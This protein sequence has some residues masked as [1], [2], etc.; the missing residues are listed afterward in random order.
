MIAY[1]S[2]AFV[3]IESKIHHSLTR[4][5]RPLQVGMFWRFLI[6]MFASSCL[7]MVLYV[8]GS[9]Y[10]QTN[11][12]RERMSSPQLEQKMEV[13][14]L[15]ALP[16]LRAAEPFNAICANVLRTL[17]QDIFTMDVLPR[18]G[19][20]SIQEVERDR[21][22]DLT[23]VRSNRAVC[24]Y[25]D[26]A[27]ATDAEGKTSFSHADIVDA[28]NWTRLDEERGGW[29]KVSSIAPLASPSEKL[30]IGVHIY[31]AREALLRLNEFPWSA[32]VPFIALLNLCCA[33]SLVPL[34]VRRIRRAQRVAN[35][36]TNG[37]VSARIHDDRQDEFGDLIH[38]F[39]HLADSFEDVIKVKQDLAA[40]D[41][42]N[43]LARDLHDT[44]KQ[45]AFALNL[46]LT[47]LTLCSSNMEQSKRIAITA[48]SLVHHLQSDLSAVIK[49]L[50]ASTIAE[51][52][53]RKV[54]GQEIHGL[55]SGAGISWTID[56]SDKVD[57][58]LQATPELTQQVFLIAIEAV[59]NALRHSSTKTIE[60]TMTEMKGRYFLSV[61]D[62]GS[63]FDVQRSSD[64]GMGLAN[65]RLRARS[66]PGSIFSIVS[67]AQA[68]TTILVEFNL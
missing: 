34:L 42:R 61:L 43:K 29:H 2:A 26:R 53:I 24:S 64:V 48:L 52:G 3:N 30:I 22:F 47:A 50:S 58:A 19:R 21:R 18:D 55:L 23:Y 14:F 44:A 31:D 41:E 59:A 15:N 5:M 32:V 8:I 36:W 68:G 62:N 33:F 45:R 56:I 10:Y 37:E 20:N 6:A 66:L 49:R 60:L 57:A 40:A 67:T 25:P 17:A 35:E 7:G 65:M 13:K 27:T 38:S 4:S 46:Q 12:L 11:K 28:G 9:V 1:M 39:N 16:M 51:D 54:I 63:G